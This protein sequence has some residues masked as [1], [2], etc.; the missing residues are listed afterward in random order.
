MEGS[1]PARRA[2]RAPVV[3]VDVANIKVLIAAGS[4]IGFGWVVNL[5]RWARP[6]GQSEKIGGFFGLHE[7]DCSAFQDSVLFRWTEGRE[8]ATFSNARSAFAA[9]IEATSPPRVWLPAYICEGL[10]ADQWRDRIRYYP[11]GVEFEPDAATLDREAASGDLVLAVDFFGFPPRSGFLNFAARRRDL[12]FVDDRA[13]ALDAGIRPWADWT[14]Y[15][16]RKLLGVADGGILVAE[17]P[18]RQVPH[19]QERPDAIALWTAPILRY[20]DRTDASNQ[21]WHQANQTKKAWMK[22]DACEMTRWSGWILSHTTLRP[23]ADRQRDNWRV[24]RDYLGR[25][26]ACEGDSDA[27]PLGYVIRV[28]TAQRPS[29]LRG[30]HGDGIFAAVHY[31]S[32][33]S[34]A[35]AFAIEHELCGQLITLPCDHRYDKASMRRVAERTLALLS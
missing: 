5:N 35:E 22:V 7:P 6:L 12:L 28:S 24:L 1:T 33:P 17:R 32:L 9:I 26:L 4:F 27:V 25:W 14:L 19:P 23:L 29:V 20:E 8:F 10:I 2:A 3:G 31:P 34:P 15:S 30:L 11:T 16:P 21:T 18:G 13:Q